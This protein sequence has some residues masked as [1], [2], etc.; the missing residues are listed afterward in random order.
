MSET[1]SAMALVW[2]SIFFIVSSLTYTFQ[3]WERVTTGCQTTS[4]PCL[5]A[6]TQGGTGTEVTVQV[7]LKRSCE[8]VAKDLTQGTEQE[9]RG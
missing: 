2:R 6:T 7:G 3:V 5:A 8:S 1:S 9:T 4:D